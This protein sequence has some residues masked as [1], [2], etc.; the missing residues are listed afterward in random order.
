MKLERGRL[1]R[2]CDCHGVWLE[3]DA[4]VALFGGW[5]C[6]FEP[7]A[8]DGEPC[9]VCRGPTARVCFTGTVPMPVCGAHGIWIDRS[10]RELLPEPVQRQLR[11]REFVDGVLSWFEST[12]RSAESGG[13]GEFSDVSTDCDGGD[14]GGSCGG[15]GG[16]CGGD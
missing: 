8:P 5:P 9:G 11:R 3:R 13:T 1:H 4:A 14:G 12:D 7:P 6:T 2:C 15:C 10:A 16:G